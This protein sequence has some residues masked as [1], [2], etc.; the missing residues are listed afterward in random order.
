[1]PHRRLYLAAYDIT[2]TARRHALCALIRAYATGGQESVYE[3]FLTASERQ[4][5]LRAV[6]AVIQDA[7]D[8]FF[9]L[10]LDPRARVMV[11]GLAQ[12][13]LDRPFFYYG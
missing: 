12:E 5:L 13:P 10:R 3:C 9:L 8:R 7:E 11:L 6:Q 1:M 4:A 2:D